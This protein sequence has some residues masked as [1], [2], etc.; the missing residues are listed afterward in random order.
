MNKNRILFPSKQRRWNKKEINILLRVSLMELV[1][2]RN[3]TLI[4]RTM[5]EYPT[6]KIIM[7]MKL[8]KWQE[9]LLSVTHHWLLFRITRRVLLQRSRFQLAISNSKEGIQYRK[10]YKRFQR[11]SVDLMK[12]KNPIQLQRIFH[13]LKCRLNSKRDKMPKSNGKKPWRKCSRKYV[14]CIKTHRT[15]TI[16]QIAQLCQASKNNKRF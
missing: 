8:L 11:N 10:T 6:N 2:I 14:I 9:H 15:T 12:A 13:R 3:T 5:L 4:N 16:Y 1:E 7:E